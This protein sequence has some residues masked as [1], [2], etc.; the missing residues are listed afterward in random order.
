[1]RPRKWGVEN[2]K[3]FL[4]DKCWVLLNCDNYIDQNS[5]IQAL[6]PVKHEVTV[7]F[8]NITDKR[9]KGGGCSACAKLAKPR[10][11]NLNIDDCH[12]SAAK[13]RGRC[14]TEIFINAMSPCEWECEFEHRWFAPLNAIRNCGSWCP[15]CFGKVK[16]TH[17]YVKEYIE[18]FG[19]TLEST[20]EA[21]WVTMKMKCPKGHQSDKSY[22][23]FRNGQR[24]AECLRISVDSA[25]LYLDSVDIVMLN[26]EEFITGKSKLN[27]Q[28]K[29]DNQH[30]WK[31]NYDHIK[32]SKTGCPYCCRFKTEP[33]VMKI[34]NDLT[35]F[36]W[37]KFRGSWLGRLELDGYCSELNAAFEYHGQQHYEF[38][39][40]FHR[41]QERFD[42]MQERDKLK[43]KL[44]KDNGV[45][46]IEIPYTYDFHDPDKLKTFIEGELCKMYVNRNECKIIG[47]VEITN[48]QDDRIDFKCTECGFTNW[49]KKQEFLNTVDSCYPNMC[50]ESECIYEDLL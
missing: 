49:Y 17:E 12:E 30:K 6:C 33:L 11:R 37:R 46:L 1:M 14:L 28:C 47:S 50:G 36:E 41:T 19:W 32:H 5:F 45:Y 20:Y 15:Q 38:N 39:K 48:I 23:N 42:S 7:K 18:S 9:S 35:G 16:L 34:L 29:R 22:N 26:K 24:C 13:N 31:T 44:C 2:M 43:K 40:F 10:K 27:L 8:V 25:Y 3:Q 4:L 21:A